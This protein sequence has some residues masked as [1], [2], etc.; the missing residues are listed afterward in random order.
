MRQQDAVSDA[1]AIH[2]VLGGKR[3]A[4]SILVRRYFPAMQALA[5]SATGSRQDAEDVVQESFLRAFRYLDHLQKPDRFAPWLAMIVKNTAQS[6][7]RQRARR[8]P[9]GGEAAHQPAADPPLEQREIHACLRREIGHLDEMYRDVLLLHYFAGIATPE[10]A[11]VLNISRSAVLKRLERGRRA[12]GDRLV[13]ALGQDLRARGQQAEDKTPQVMGLVLAAQAPWLAAGKAAAAAA[14]PGVAQGLLATALHHKLAVSVGALLTALCATL[15]IGGGQE[16]PSTID[17][18]T[19]VAA[20]ATAIAT[21]DPPESMSSP[22][23]TPAPPPAEQITDRPASEREA[24][25]PENLTPARRV[26]PAGYPGSDAA[27]ATR[28]VVEGVVL[29]PHRRPLPGARVWAGRAGAGVPDTRETRSDGQGKFSIKLPDGVW[30]VM[31]AKEMLGGEADAG[32]DGTIIVEGRPATVRTTVQTEE[33]SVLRGRLLDKRTGKP[34][35]SGSVFTEDLR[36]IPV[37]ALGCF[38]IEGLRSEDHTFVARCPGYK[39]QYVLFSTVLKQ[40]VTLDVPLEPGVRVAGIVTDTAGSPVAGAWVRMGAS[41]TGCMSGYYE[42]CDE[43]GRFE[44]DGVAPDREVFMIA[45]WPCYLNSCGAST[46]GTSQWK[47]IVTEAKTGLNLILPGSPLREARTLPTAFHEPPTSVI[48]GRVVGPDGKPM[49][50]FHV[51]LGLTRPSI[52]GSHVEVHYTDPGALFTADDGAFALTSDA[53]PGMFVSVMASVEGFRDALVEKAMFRPMASPRPADA[54]TLRLGDTVPVTVRVVD[55]DSASRP[56]EGARVTLAYPYWDIRREGLRL[57]TVAGLSRPRQGVTDARGNALFEDV[58]FVDGVIRVDCDGYAVNGAGW[59]GHARSVTVSLE[60]EC[61]LE[62]EVLAEDG[63][64]PTRG[65]GL[66]VLKGSPDGSFDLYEDGAV[67][68]E[69]CIR[70]EDGGK[71]HITGLPPRRYSLYLSWQEGGANQCFFM[72]G[73]PEQPVIIMAGDG[74]TVSGIVRESRQ[75]E[76]SDMFALEAGQTL[77]V[78]YPRDDSRL[79]PDRLAALEAES[80]ADVALHRLLVGVWSRV[81]AGPDGA[82]VHEVLQFGED[83]ALCIRIFASPAP[84]VG[85]RGFVEV[86]T[87]TFSVIDGEVHFYDER[88]ESWWPGGVEADDTHIRWNDFLYLRKTKGIDNAIREAEAACGVS[89]ERDLL[90]L[91]ELGL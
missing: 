78:S 25:T 66:V 88:G 36:L 27:E 24:E 30:G 56:I 11:S 33:R 91:S 38:V 6:L 71:F 74:K 80:S 76:Y 1:D 37:D 34:L 57:D 41:G 82:P 42:V 35:S 46:P 17:A 12:L 7:L 39:R 13:D 73:A 67:F 28:H 32:P 90:P 83:G 26:A 23:E 48:H 15:V 2:T 43:R 79:N 86:F 63:S 50:V 59:D 75:M 58:A 4:F 29:D 44:Y 5:F 45:R 53:E 81:S 14:A 49:P 9:V 47:G 52:P 20:A 72:G 8:K 87:G 89:L 31:A 22:P 3:D 16:E 85:K 10:I 77:H 51:R 64:G 40:E 62:G 21:L 70:W 61:V 68:R 65:E 60:P 19:H 54:V 55:A 18:E 69:H 84:A